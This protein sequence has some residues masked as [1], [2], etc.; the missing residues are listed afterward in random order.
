MSVFLHQVTEGLG[1]PIARQYMEVG[2]PRVTIGESSFQG[3]TADSRGVGSN[4][5]VIL[6]SFAAFSNLLISLR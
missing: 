6:V 2:L 5:H 4:M 1:Q 3:T